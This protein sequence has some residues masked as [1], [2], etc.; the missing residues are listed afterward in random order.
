V[1]QLKVTLAAET[2]LGCRLIR[3][4]RTTFAF[5]EQGQLEA[6]FILGGEDSRTL[7]SAEFLWG[8]V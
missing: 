5:E 7:G 3:S 2:K 1:A 4:Q 6:D 8:N